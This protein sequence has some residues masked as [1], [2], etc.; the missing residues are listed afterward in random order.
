[1]C[2]R[3]AARRCWRRCAT[4]WCI[5]CKGWRRPARQRPPATFTSIPTKPSLSCL[6]DLYLDTALLATRIDLVLAFHAELDRPD[7][8]R[9]TKHL[10][11]LAA[12]GIE[13]RTFAS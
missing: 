13:V 1:V 5:C 2:G 7:R 3:G 8:G 9:G 12:V 10:I 11:G 6:P 4:G